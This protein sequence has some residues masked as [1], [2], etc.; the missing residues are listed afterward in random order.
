M[1]TKRKTTLPKR[2]ASLLLALVMVVS[3]LPTQIVVAHAAGETLTTDKD[4]YTV[5]EPI[6]VTTNVPSGKP[7]AAIYSSG[8]AYG[9]GYWCWWYAHEGEHTYNL[10]DSAVADDSDWGGAMLPAGQYDININGTS[11]TKTITIVAPTDNTVKSLEAESETVNFGEPIRVKATSYKDGA[12]V[13]IYPGTYDAG[14]DFSTTHNASTDWYYCSGN[15]GAYC[16][17][18]V[19]SGA[20]T[21]VYVESGYVAE[22]VVHVTVKEPEVEILTTDKTEY[23]FGDSI[24]VTVNPDNLPTLS[25]P[26]YNWVALH[27]K[28]EDYKTVKSIYWYYITDEGCGYTVDLNWRKNDN[29]RNE[30]SRDADFIAGEYTVTLMTKDGNDWYSYIDSVDI[31]ITTEIDENKTKTVAPTCEENGSVTYT[32]TDGTTK[33]VQWDDIENVELMEELEARGHNYSAKPEPMDGVVGKH[34]YTCGNDGNHTKE[35]DCAWDE[36]EVTVEPEV[37]KDGVMTYTCTV[38]DGKRTETISA[39]TV[40]RTDTFEATCTKGSYK[41]DYYTDGTDS[42]EIAT[43]IAALGHT[44]DKPVH[45]EDSDPSSHTKTCTRVGCTVDQT[46]HAVT[47]NCAYDSS[48]VPGGTRYTCSGCGDSY[49]EIVLST[50]KTEYAF[51]QDINVNVA[52]NGGDGYWIGIYRYLEKIGTGNCVSIYWMD[53]AT[54]GTYKILDGVKAT[55]RPMSDWAPGYTYTIYLFSTYNYDVVTSVDVYVGPAVRDE[56]KT[57]RVEPTC[58]TDGSITYYLTDGT[59]DEVIDAVKEPSL[60]ATDHAYPEKFTYD[61]NKMTHSKVCTNAGCTDAQEGHIKTENCTW[62]NGVEK[63]PATQEKEGVMEYTC[64]VCEGTK[65]E[66]IPKLSI[67]ETGRDVVDPTCTEQGYTRVHYS[68]G[69]Y[70]DIEFVAAL[71]HDWG[72]YAHVEGTRTHT[73]ICKRDSK[74]VET[75]N[76]QLETNGVPEGSTL[77]FNCGKCGDFYESIIMTDKKVYASGEDIIITINPNWNGT[78]LDWIGLYKKNERPNQEKNPTSIRWDYVTKFENGMSIFESNWHDRPTEDPDNCLP[79]GEYWLY[80]C[81]ND[82]YEVVCYET[83]TVTPVVDHDER[84]EPTCDEDGYVTRYYKGGTSEVLTWEDMNDETLKKLGHD[85]PAKW[86]PAGD[87]S[88]HTRTCQRDDC[89]EVETENCDWDDGVETIPP[90]ESTNGEMTYTCSVCEGTRTE[91]IAATGANEIN[92]EVFDPTCEDQGYTRVYYDNDTYTDMDFVPA[93]GHAYPEKFTYHATAKT[94]SKVCANDSKHVIIENCNF[95]VDKVNGTTMTF[96]CTV[97]GGSY[98]TGILATDKTTYEVTDPIMVT[99]YNYVGAGSWVGLYK[100]GE[101]Y[102]PNNGGVASLFWANVSQSMV[103]KA[104]DLTAVVASTSSGHRGEALSNGN[105][106]LVL[107]GDSGYSNVIDIVELTVF[108]DTSNTEFTVKVNDR[109]LSDGETLELAKG[110]SVELSVSAAGKTG[111][112]WIGMYKGFLDEDSLFSTDP[113]YKNDITETG[114]AEDLTDQTVD[115]GTYTFIVFGDGGYE[116]VRMFAYISIP[117][118]ILSEEILEEPTCTRPGVKLIKFDKNGDGDY[119]AG[120]DGYE[121]VDIPKLG[122]DWGDWTQVSGTKTHTRVCSRK[123]THTETKPCTFVEGKCTDCGAEDHVCTY[124]EKFTYNN[125]KATHSKVCAGDS[126][127][128]ITENCS[129]GDAVIV[130]PA[131][132]NNAGMKEYTCSVCGGSYTEAFYAK[133]VEGTYDRVQGETRY[134]TSLSAA[135][136]LKENIGVEKFDAVVVACGTD[137]ADA[138]SGSY[139]A[140]QK[141]APILLVRNNNEDIDNVKDYIKENVAPGGTVYLL[142]GSAVV[143]KSLEN[144]L[145]GYAVKRLFGATRYETNLAILQEAGVAGKDIL[146]CTGKNFADGLSASATNMPVLL[147]K[148]SLTD[149]QKALLASAGGK[150]YIIGGTGVVSTK[151]E[152]ALSAYGSVERVGG[153]TRYETSV[154]IAKKFFT[155][156]NCAALVSGLNFPDGLC[157]GPVAHS[158][159]AP[160]ILAAPGKTAAAKAYAN[161]AGIVTGTVLGGSA[162]VSNA[163]ANEVFG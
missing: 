14:H 110:D 3:L 36:G 149:A 66:T 58:T 123:N 38:C 21:V 141:G 93:I 16:E 145:N 88:T 122:H 25:E 100:E 56:S 159:G 89:G 68:D 6:M 136:Q 150:I 138:L 54:A 34:V 49:D 17:F 65:T 13:G 77:Y 127:H 35:E 12:W 157:A 62:D 7:W 105:Y 39:K 5:G 129:F 98:N 128:K 104:F 64:T 133:V 51:G 69:S 73:R 161:E 155:D 24:M 2:I 84:T 10:Y 41:I 97:C 27:K 1:K 91:P 132:G 146:V 113:L 139:L 147:V 107:F 70:Q 18:N 11:A 99:V 109:I 47:E 63:E 118:D 80:L 4:V 152:S 95:E 151:L 8:T 148:D 137:F 45:N 130:K 74:H 48:A 103:G 126:N 83:I 163:V 81:K 71:D 60:K 112:S 86:N 23:E 15:N 61:D 37:G 158:M 57:V 160:L 90:T 46:D 116:D 33:T 121:Y 53:T 22:K 135:D 52:V 72:E 75:E 87:K 101:M 78:N 26:E 32:Y 67:T 79:A 55:D 120:V 162:V 131:V 156:T 115:G 114:F 76:C 143:P 102:D 28:G 142:G 44:Y 43:G 153:A 40:A 20:W 117:R 124:P 106:E 82:G 59:V 29:V 119:T 9:S 85:F 134:E 111:T 94:H 154:N 96:K 31:T 50:D 125:D 140:C 92:R 19:S 144:G 42:G 30:N 108:T